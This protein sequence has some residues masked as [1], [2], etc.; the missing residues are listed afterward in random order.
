MG[1]E[2]NKKEGG[3]DKKHFTPSLQAQKTALPLIYISKQTYVY[4]LLIY[5]GVHP[6]LLERMGGVRSFPNFIFF[7][8]FFPIQKFPLHKQHIVKNSLKECGLPLMH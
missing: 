1:K 2:E 7:N 8:F 5:R 6:P 4:K 3:G